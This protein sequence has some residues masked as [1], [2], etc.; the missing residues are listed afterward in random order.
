MRTLFVGNT[1]YITNEFIENAFPDSLV[2]VMGAAC[3]KTD[4]KKNVVVRPFTKNEKEQEDIFCTYEFEQI[5]YFSYYLT[6]HGKVEGEADRLR[7]I[8]QYCKNKKNMKII[9][10]TGPEATYD[11]PT[12]KTVLASNMV[13]YQLG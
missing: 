9:Y 2:V 8:L 5:V 12:G 4:R 13:F 10:L 6:L 11:V 3:I 1:G 7:K